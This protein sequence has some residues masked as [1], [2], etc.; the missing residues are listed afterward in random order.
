MADKTASGSDLRAYAMRLLSR[1][2]YA[3]REL[4]SKVCNKW[5]G[6]DDIEFLADQLVDDLQQEGSL[7]DERYVE[8]FV[9][10][11]RQ[12]SQGP[13]KIRAELRQKQLPDSLI[14]QYLDSEEQQW[15]D[16]ASAWLARQDTGNLDF[17]GR[18]KFY[19]R[20]INRGFSHDQAMSALGKP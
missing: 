5:R 9:R 12:R 7:S 3:V 13:L 10:S 1:R 14:E 6:Q 20:L 18:A 17:E 8:A 2:E 4:H 16:L 19:R 11:R 15:L